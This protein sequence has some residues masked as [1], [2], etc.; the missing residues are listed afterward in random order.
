MPGYIV[1]G[2]LSAKLQLASHVARTI[3][4]GYRVHTPQGGTEVPVLTHGILFRD[5]RYSDVNVDVAI[6]A[7]GFKIIVILLTLSIFKRLPNH[8]PEAIVVEMFL[9]GIREVFIG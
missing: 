3:P 7:S 8:W 1:L 9:Q 5:K 4:C 2:Q 6:P